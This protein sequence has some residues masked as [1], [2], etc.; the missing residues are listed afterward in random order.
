MKWVEHEVADRDVSRSDSQPETRECASNV[1][2]EK[3]FTTETRRHG[4]NQW[5][6]R[7]GSFETPNQSLKTTC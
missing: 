6:G 7:S 4:V 2:G 1:G 3:K 5:S